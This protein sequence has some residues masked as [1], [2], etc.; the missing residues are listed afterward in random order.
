MTLVVAL[1]THAAQ[2]DANIPTTL[3]RWADAGYPERLFFRVEVP[4]EAGNV[5]LHRDLPAAS[6]RLALRRRSSPG[7]PVGP[8]TPEKILLIG[9]DGKPQ[10]VYPHQS[11]GDPDVEFRFRTQPGLRRFCLYYGAP[12]NGHQSF[13]PIDYAPTDIGLSMRGRSAPNDFQYLPEKPLTLE[14]F[15]T[16]ERNAVNALGVLQPAAIDDPECPFVS[17]TVDALGR[18]PQRIDPERYVAVYEGFLRTPIRGNYVFALDTPGV[19]Y[20][21]IDGISVL[22]ADAPDDDRA[23]FELQ[24]DVELKE[25]VHRIVVYY[26][27]GNPA[28]KTNAELQRFGLRLHWKPPWARTLMCVPPDAFLHAL[29]VVIVRHE[30]L[31]GPVQTA[32]NGGGTPSPFIQSEVL[33]HV[34]CAVHLGDSAGLEQALVYLRAMDA[35]NAESLV[36]SIGN[37]VIFNE[38]VKAEGLLKWVPAGAD[39]TAAVKTT[40]STEP[41]AQRLVHVQTSK[42]GRTGVLDLEGELELKNAPDFLYPDETAHIHIQTSLS[43]PPRIIPKERIEANL[44]LAPARPMGEFRLRWSVRTVINTRPTPPPQEGEDDATPLKNGRRL[45]RVSL[46][47]SQ[48][49]PLSKDGN[50]QIVLT[51]LIGDVECESIRLCVL[52]AE[53]PW[54]GQVVAGAGNLLFVPQASS[55]PVNNQHGRQDACAT[56]MLLKRQNDADYRE[57]VPLRS[58]ASGSLGNSALFLGDPLVEGLPVTQTST[59]EFGIAGMLAHATPQLKWEQI[60]IAGPH[61]S[62][63]VF[64]FIAELEKYLRAKPNGVGNKVPALVLLSIGAGDAARQTPLY[65]F[66][67]ALDA[68]LDRL[69]ANGARKIVIVGVIPEVD[70]EANAE[71]YQQK[72][73]D[74]ERQHHLTGVDV[75]NTWTKESNWTQRYLLDKDQLS[76]FGPLPNTEALEEISKMIE[77]QIR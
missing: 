4:A 17:V 59:Q 46:M 20:V 49:D 75:F 34:R 41:L 26:A 54:P 7:D 33:G 29:P 44:L 39:I 42:E 9:E 28:G 38:A 37:D 67:R 48:L 60:Y 10:P 69:K 8:L 70:R 73:L 52:N 21:L 76:V 64:R 77:E 23:P 18:N 58:A 61:R 2:T 25:G 6:I 65:T 14:R 32:Q 30:N 57:F 43:P 47:G 72:V 63:P 66:E 22:S 50:T 15:Q 74:L 13:S 36:L 19:A 5:D 71:P 51:L 24:H 1:V 55:L 3:T 31:S 11:T 56:L 62:L 35:T 12:A 40:K 16:M 68:L 27:E 53:N 45:D